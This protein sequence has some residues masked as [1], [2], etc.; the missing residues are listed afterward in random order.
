[1]VFVPNDFFAALGVVRALHALRRG[2]ALCW[3]QRRPILLTDLDMDA[4]TDSL[5]LARA[6][7]D[8]AWPGDLNKMKGDQIEALLLEC[9]E[10]FRSLAVALTCVGGRSEIDFVSGGR[11]SFRSTYEWVTRDDSRR[12]S[13]DELTRVLRGPRR[14]VKGGKSFRWAPLAAQD[15]RRPRTATND[16]R[17]EPWV[18]WLALQGVQALLA[19]PAPGRRV[20]YETRS[21]ALFRPAE[22]RLKLP[23]LAALANAP[24]RGR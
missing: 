15:A 9:T 5:L 18:E 2:V 16:S 6:Q 8:G 19:T 14:L 22:P 20:P 24:C 17:S 23:A 7:F 13:R 1:M 10:P 11:G 3:K 4:L 21:T 12:F